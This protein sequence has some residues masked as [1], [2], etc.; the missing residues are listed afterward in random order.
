MYSFYLT[1]LPCISLNPKINLFSKNTVSH[2]Y[3]TYIPIPCYTP[4]LKYIMVETIFSAFQYNHFYFNIAE[5][6][7]DGNTHKI[8]N[9]KL[10]YSLY[11]KFKVLSV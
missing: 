9:F 8:K 11:Y 10:N 5:N 6:I 4:S 2:H 3:N 1:V 7:L